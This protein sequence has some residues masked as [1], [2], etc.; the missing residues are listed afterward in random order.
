MNIGFLPNARK[1][2]QDSSGHV[3]GYQVEGRIV[4]YI[5]V[6]N[7]GDF[8]NTGRVV[9]TSLHF[10]IHVLTYSWQ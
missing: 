10:S 2:S 5:P 8:S 7:P 9:W 3:S 1:E 4:L 6:R